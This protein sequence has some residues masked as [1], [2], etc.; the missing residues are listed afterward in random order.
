MNVPYSDHEIRELCRIA[1]QDYAAEVHRW[2]GMF[3][4]TVRQVT[5]D[6]APILEAARLLMEPGGVYEVRIP[7]AGRDGTLSGYFD[8]PEALAAAAAELDGRYPAIYVTLNPTKPALLARA[9]NRIQRHATLTTTDPDISCRR[10][11]L[12]DVDPVRP[13]GVSS[14]DQEHKLA[15]ETA[16]TIWR[17]LRTAG[18]P[19]PVAA[20]SGNGCHLLYRVEMPNAEASAKRVKRFLDWLAKKYGTA[21]VAIDTSV[22]NAGRITKLY[23]TW[24]R[25]GD[26][27][28][29]RPHRVSKI[30]SAPNP[31]EVA[32]I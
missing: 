30:L 8:T 28:P 15:I 29:D 13:A 12:I 20:D 31:W 17:D 2:K 32:S 23:G 1:D 27:I 9:A 11:V 10:L 24:A 7:K 26:N 18:L 5:R 6:P 4:G 14:T 19:A 21:E 3:R 25:K 16:R 22:Y